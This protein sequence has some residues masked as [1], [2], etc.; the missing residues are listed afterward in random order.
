MTKIVK[1]ISVFFVIFNLMNFALAENTFFEEGKKKYDEKRYDESKFLF[2]RSIVFYPKDHES[3]LYLAK[4]FKFEDNKKE[5]Q[6]NID[7][8][9]LLDPKNEE[10][11]YFL[12]EIELNKSNYSKVKELAENFSKIC[13]KLCDKKTFILDSLKNLE[14]KNES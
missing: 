7:T 6:K 14:P 13:K 1:I 4:I 8:V 10:A 3:Y 11:N 12:M 2:Q 9:I 5:E